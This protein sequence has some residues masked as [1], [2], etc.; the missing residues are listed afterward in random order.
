MGLSSFE[1][2]NPS[3]NFDLKRPALGEVPKSGV[4]GER[5]CF[6]RQSEEKDFFDDTEDTEYAGLFICDMPV[7]SPGLLLMPGLEN[8]RVCI[9]AVALLTGCGDTAEAMMGRI[10]LEVAGGLLTPDDLFKG[11]RMRKLFFFCAAC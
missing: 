3:L 1:L 11:L 7:S 4:V 9:A 10:S 5:F 8:D 6:D 2:S